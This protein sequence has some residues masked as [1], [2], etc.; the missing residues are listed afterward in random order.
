MLNL[1]H[2]EIFHAIM[3]TGSMTAAAQALNISQP[4]VS[5]V[6]KHFESRLQMPL[7]KRVGGRLKPTPEAL[8]LLPDIAE[9]FTRLD[10]IERFSRDLAGGLRGSVSVVATSPLANGFLTEAVALFARER[11]LAKVALQ[12]LGSPQVLERVRRREADIG[13]AYEPIVSTEVQSEVLTIGSIACVLPES[14]PLARQESISPADLLP[15]PIITYLPQALLRPYVDKALSDA[16]VELGISIEVG[17]SIT[18]IMLA[19]HGAG[20]ALV[21]PDL[22]TALRLPTLTSRPLVPRV[23]VRSLLILNRSAP[24]SRIVDEFVQTLRTLARQAPGASPPG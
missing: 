22:L 10:A 20:I 1:R 15:Y 9:I 3:R 5:A 2:I 4:A 13:V 16:G 7:F 14:H 8:A 18:G 12:A 21:E 23:E 11:P 6:L 19:L 17:L 24:R